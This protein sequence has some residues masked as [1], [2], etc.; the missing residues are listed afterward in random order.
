MHTF[1]LDY[2]CQQLLVFIVLRIFK[3]HF[4]DNRNEWTKFVGLCA[5]N[6]YHE[7]REMQFQ[8]V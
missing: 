3:A 2:T 7:H 8:K 1:I 5:V 4:C 6:E